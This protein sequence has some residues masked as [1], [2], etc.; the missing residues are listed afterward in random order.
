MWESVSEENLRKGHL[1][2]LSKAV[3]RVDEEVKCFL[4]ERVPWARISSVLGIAGR[5]KSLER[6]FCR[7]QSEED[8]DGE[9]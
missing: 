6:G 1:S 7:R 4:E 2:F 8:V 3:S 9:R 5:L